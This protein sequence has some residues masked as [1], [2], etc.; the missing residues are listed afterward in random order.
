MVHRMPH[1]ILVEEDTKAQQRQRS[2]VRKHVM[3][4]YQ[5][6]SLPEQKEK[7]AWGSAGLAG[8]GIRG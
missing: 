6:L 3:Q 1:P 2:R 4:G 5:T 7:Q 8:K